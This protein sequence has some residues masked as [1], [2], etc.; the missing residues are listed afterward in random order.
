M[1]EMMNHKSFTEISKLNKNMHE[2][3]GK[4]K[5]TNYCNNY[6]IG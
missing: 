4:V 1:M 5:G 3:K 2:L 6:R